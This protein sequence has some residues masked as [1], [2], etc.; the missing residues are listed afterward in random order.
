M[1]LSTLIDIMGLGTWWPH[2]L[3]TLADWGLV[4]H[5]KVTQ[6]SKQTTAYL[7][8][9]CWC[10][11]QHVFFLVLIFIFKKC[12]TNGDALWHNGLRIQ[13]YRYGSSGGFYGADSIPGSGTSACHGLCPLKPP[14]RGRW[15]MTLQGQKQQQWPLPWAA[16]PRRGIWFCI[17][18]LCLTEIFRKSCLTHTY[19]GL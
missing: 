5:C 4:Y 3:G 12:C 16:G 13:Y 2:C 6:R 7:Y 8:L 19:F 18:Y 15:R 10:F 11:V 14:K 9:K 1:A 17:N